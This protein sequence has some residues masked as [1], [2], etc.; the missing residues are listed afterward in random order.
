MLILFR[1]IS[2]PN[3]GSG[4]VF[5]SLTLANEIHNHQII[6]ITEDS[7]KLMVER[8]IKNQFP[9]ISYKRSNIVKK[10]IS[11][12]PDIVINDILDT[13]LEDVM[14][15]KKAGVR[16]I[17]FED[18]G[19]GASESDITINELFETPILDS[20]NI[21][22]GS[23]YFFVREEFDHAIVHEESNK[24]SSVLISFGGIDKLNCTLK[25]YEAIKELCKTHH[26]KINIV[27]GPGYEHYKNLQEI[28]RDNDLVVL[29][30][31]TGVISSIMEKCEIAITSNGRTVYELT[32]MNIPTIAIP[33]NEREGT[34]EF[35]SYQTGFIV[36]NKN[37]PDSDKIINDIFDAFQQLVID[38]S[39]RNKLFSN[40][41]NHKFDI[42]RKKV[43][44]LI[45]GISTKV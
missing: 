6:F 36:L 7:E 43:K 20:D 9:V 5:R 15:L 1:V 29:T 24:V 13:N 30:N 34:H 31:A 4:H 28:T 44:E 19:M 8:I 33:Q 16:V 45:L 14:P 2:N 38:H 35:A 21:L 39:Q 18:L 3:V 26:I 11:L 12:K 25:A 32:H 40:M 22:W 42:N 17:N 41:Q 27:T 23:K 37:K 10:I